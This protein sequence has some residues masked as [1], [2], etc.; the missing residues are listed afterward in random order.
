MGD[1]M[2]KG[3]G[4]LVFV[5]G[6][7]G[8]GYWGSKVQAVAMES[9]I[10]AGAE[11]VTA[12]SVHP[13]DLTVSGRDIT[14]TGFADTEDELAALGAELEGLRG[15]RVV[16]LDGIT[17]LPRVEPY[18]TALAKGEDGALAATGYAPSEAAIAAL[19]EA[20]LPVEDLALA[21][22]APEG[23]DQA[24]S[25][26]G[27]ALGSLD[28][29][30]FAVTGETLT[31][32]GV[33]ATPVE[34][35]AAHAALAVPGTYE[36][37]VAIDVT[38]PGVVDFSLDYDAGRGF[39]LDGI[40]PESFG[41]ESFAGA[42]GADVSAGPIE[43]TFARMPDITPALAGLGEVLPQLESLAITGTNDGLTA[44]AEAQ[45][46]LDTDAVSAALGAVLGGDVA[47][48]VNAAAPPEDG[49][50]RVSPV[51]GIR[52]FAHAGRWLALP[53]GLDE[54]TGEACA[55]RA[56]D[57]VQAS[58]ILFVTGS[59]ELDPA[60]L[61]VIEELAGI[62]NLCTRGPGMIVTIGGHTDA[63]GDPE[64]NYVLSA[65]R[66]RAVKDALAARGVTPGRMIAIGYGE[67]EPIADNET[68]EGRAQNRRTT[69]TWPE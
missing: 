20:G 61:A 51:T 67:T 60:S 13:L 45:A 25:A 48:E 23:W 53:E 68:E 15:R 62:I 24:L 36:T 56:M 42:L 16:N 46:G 12:A 57:R 43:T 49:T 37:V 52:Q 33:A 3:L 64:D 30:S 19:A 21:S 18:E 1:I 27:A 26:G 63:T 35:D 7:A 14:V 41:A 44:T 5:A 38:D 54:P 8:L 39:A 32:E 29:G 17:V 11:A 22:G 9:E 69:F 47:L 31:L 2:S 50:E 66:A 40:L 65:Q 10:V 6:V 59:A 58:P 4:A 34:S 28:T 55:T